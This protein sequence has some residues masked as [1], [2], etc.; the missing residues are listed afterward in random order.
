[1]TYNP[2]FALLFLY[3]SFDFKIPK[4]FWL[5]VIA[6]AVTGFLAVLNPYK[7]FTFVQI[8]LIFVIL[9]VVRIFVSAIKNKRNDN[10]IIASGFIL[11]SIFSSYDIFMDL[12]V[13]LPI[14]GIVNGYPFGFVCLIFYASIYL[15]RDFSRA[16]KNI[17]IKE[18]EAK[19]MEIAQKVLEAE[20][21]RKTFELKEARDVR[22]SLLPQFITKIQN[23][24]FYFEMHP[25]T[26]IG[27]DYFDYKVPDEVKFPFSSAMLQTMV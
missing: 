17:L 13:I 19:K 5:L 18:R 14:D 12:N 9:E 7:Y 20:D 26:E 2:P 15:A 24:E 10:W 1:M 22:L 6:L 27:G 16:N 4:Y 21:N 11:L 3:Y 25:A 23:Y 8:P